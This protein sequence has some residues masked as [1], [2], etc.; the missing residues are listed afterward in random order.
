MTHGP[1]PYIKRSMQREYAARLAI[2]ILAGGLGNVAGQLSAQPG[3]A[4]RFSGEPDSWPADYQPS[5]DYYD[6]HKSAQPERPGSTN[7]IKAWS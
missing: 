6:W 2:F 1:A 3:E 7:M 4:R 5:G